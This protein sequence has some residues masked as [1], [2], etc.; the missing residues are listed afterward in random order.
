MRVAFVV[1]EPRAQRAEH[2][3][4]Y[5]ALAALRRG[6]DV[7]FVGVDDLTLVADDRVTAQVIRPAAACAD[8]HA[9]C[10]ALAAADARVSDEPLADWDVLFLRYHPLQDGVAA[11]HPAAN[12]GARLQTAGVLVVND[13]EGT[14]RAGARMYLSGL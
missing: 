8:N 6:H 2:T 1:A 5:L 11:A 10:A 3:T 7:G 4:P 12:F 9:L 13:P 14:Q